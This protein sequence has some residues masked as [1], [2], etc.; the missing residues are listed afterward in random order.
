MIRLLDIVRKKILENKN[1]SPSTN[2]NVYFGG[3][4]QHG[5]SQNSQAQIE[6][7]LYKLTMEQTLSGCSDANSKEIIHNVLQYISRKEYE[8]ELEAVLDLCVATTA[9]Q[10]RTPFFFYFN[11]SEVKL[12]LYI[13]KAC[14][15]P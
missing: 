2:I 10:T 15:V 9:I 13:I 8:A 1:D 4:I 11:R 6:G 7:G 14:D 5:I 12:F 3:S